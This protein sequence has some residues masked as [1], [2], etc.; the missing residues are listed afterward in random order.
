MSC[1]MGPDYCIYRGDTFNISLTVQ[2]DDG[3][4]IDIT[5]YA[6][7]FSMKKSVNDQAI[8]LTKQATITDGVN[9]LAD[10]TFTENDT[11][12]DIDNYFYDVEFRNEFSTIVQ[13]YQGRFNIQQDI[14]P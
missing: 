6:I 1:A 10:I 14:Q 9:G 4:P 7:R 12:Q 3:S 11:D 8:V 13:T 2:N 5:N